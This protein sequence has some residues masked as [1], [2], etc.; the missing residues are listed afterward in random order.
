MRKG[1]ILGLRWRHVDLNAGVFRLEPDEDLKIKE[2]KEKIVPINSHVRKVLEA[3]PSPINPDLPVFTFHGAEIKFKDSF[4]NGFAGACRRAKIF[5]GQKV[6]G[7]ITFHDLRRTFQTN[8]LAAKVQESMIEI[9]VGHSLKGMKT[10][11][12]HPSEDDLK[13]AMDQYTIWWDLQVE[14]GKCTKKVHKKSDREN[15]TA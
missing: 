6:E 7:G 11:Y 10:H 12:L 9:I 15:S 2:G 13:R 5:Y 8:M 14:K 1:E 3:L 4:K